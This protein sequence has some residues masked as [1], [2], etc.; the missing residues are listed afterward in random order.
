MRLAHLRSLVLDLGEASGVVLR[1]R[2]R[3]RQFLDHVPDAPPS[4]EAVR[5]VVMVVSELVA[6]AYRHATGPRRLTLT[7]DDETITV[8]VEDG[9]PDGLTPLP[10]APASGGFGLLVIRR[11][12]RDVDVHPVPGGKRVI[13]TVPRQPNGR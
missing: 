9:R 7:A 2:E 5:D 6:N 12:C 8:A 1:V 3:T 13:A 10:T 11:L 4:A